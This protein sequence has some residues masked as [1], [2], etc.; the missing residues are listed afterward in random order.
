MSR[1]EALTAHAAHLAI[2][3]D[4]VDKAIRELRGVGGEA[5]EPALLLDLV[6][7]ELG[8]LYDEVRDE[9]EEWHPHWRAGD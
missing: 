6:R 3:R 8:I 7:E 4:A 2:A 5:Q 1:R 9:L